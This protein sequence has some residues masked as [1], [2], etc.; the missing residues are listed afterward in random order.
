MSF[1]YRNPT[2]A[3]ILQGADTVTLDNNTGTNFSVYSIGGY[4][5]VYSHEDLNFIIPS[6]SSGTILYSG[7]TIPINFVYGAPLSSPD[8]VNIETDEISCGRRRLGMMVYVISAATTYQ[9]E[10]D[11][12]AALW[13]AA[14]IAV[15]LIGDSVT[16]YQCYTNTVA[17]QKFVS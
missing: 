9:F 8:A 14:E 10:I 12:Y 1:Q 15:S 7:N 11:N 3:V 13:D 16:G 4:M 17:G 6:G 2:S 5:E